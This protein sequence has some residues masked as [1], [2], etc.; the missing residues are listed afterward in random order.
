[1]HPPRF[2]SIQ[3]N[4]LIGFLTVTVILTC[5]GSMLA[6]EVFRHNAQQ[7][8]VT[9][10]G[11][12][13]NER[14]A[15]ERDS[16][17]ALD[18]KHRAVIKAL[19]VRLSSRADPAI[20]DRWFP[21]QADGTRRSIPALF[22]GYDT[23][24]GDHV[25]GMGAF[26]GSGRDVSA[27]DK[28]F[29]LAV[30]QVVRRFG[31]G[32]LNQFDNLYFYDFRNR[33]IIFGP[34]R[35]DKLLFYRQTAPAS[36]DLNSTE[37][38]RLI[39]PKFNPKGATRCTKLA[40]Y[41]PDTTHRTLSTG[42]M[43][44]VY[45]NGK[46]RGGV[47]TTLRIGSYLSQT[48]A[49]SPLGATS[50]IVDHEGSLIAY[51]GFKT[52]GS[53]TPEAVERYQTALHVKDIVGRIGA[54][55]KPEGVIDGP[56][57]LDL[58]AYSHLAGPGWI[59]LVIFPKQAV[60]DAALHSALPVIVAGFAAVLAELALLFWLT[61]ELLVAP[62]L[63]LC[64]NIGWSPLGM[65]MARLPDDSEIRH[66]VDRDDEIGLLARTL[67]EARER[68]SN[69][70]LELEQRVQERT[71]ELE[72]ANRAK[73]TFLANMSHELRTPLN[74]VIALSELMADDAPTAR[75]KSAAELVVASGRLLEQVL[76]DIL[77][78]SKIEAGQMS[79]HSIDFD[80][81]ACVNRIAALHRAS[82]MAKGLDM[83]WHIAPAAQGW[84][85]GDDIRVTQILSNLLSNAVKFTERGEVRLDVD[86]TD[87]GLEFR[88]SDTGAG[89]SPDI[90]ERLFRRFEQADDSATRRY[91]GSGL[92]LAIC[93]S[94]VQMMKGRIW[95][96]STLGE[97]AEF[98]VF[99]PL[100]AVRPQ[101][102]DPEDV[103]AEAPAGSGL[104]VL[105][106]ED[107]PTNQ[108]VVS[109]IL[110]P[111]GVELVMVANGKEALEAYATEAFDLI[112]MDLQMPVMDGLTSARR[113]RQVE[114]ASG[115]P[116]TP[117]FAVTAN[118]L[119]E[120]VAQTR[121]A[122][123]DGHISKPYRPADLINLLSLV[124]AGRE[125]A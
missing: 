74:G 47:G 31:E 104:R 116:H 82:A 11:L 70:M 26:F 76:T 20:F 48:I 4:L 95:A 45:L 73:S 30:T 44:P 86:R 3:L 50:L 103:T 100:E 42:C 36:L 39:D 12:Y 68:S 87:E 29:Y 115:R 43:T 57:H 21:L 7:Q 85:H 22:D 62:L 53:V 60:T 6:F 19:Q 72:D 124:A 15:S 55:A 24:E 5:L 84:V 105:V 106:A 14:A 33:V 32:N 59:Y 112:L 37:M 49:K 64:R 27:D 63:T 118:A 25:Y 108:K 1:V 90:R 56:D 89:F 66:L 61:R 65:D 102:A 58:V 96:D 28:R 2:R 46:L 98:S 101:L 34:A 54:A 111:T 107:H 23:P 125:E 18:G 120:H 117:I 75:S 40:P 81:D 80:L 71:R 51:P 121:Q 93:A 119:P 88:V 83:T 94:L 9:D 91:G 41:L 114:A 17:K 8:R 109:L 77:D 13:I 10:L 113:I 97:G 38:A 67:E 79:I 122:G 35:E 92:G 16:F 78:F 69:V 99:L 110:E 52:P 123:M